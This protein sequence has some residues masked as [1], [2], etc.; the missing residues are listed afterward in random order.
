MRPIV[1]SLV[2]WTLLSTLASGQQQDTTMIP[3]ELALALIDVGFSPGG[4]PA[5]SVGHV[6][7]DFPTE[8]LPK[9]V[10]VLGTLSRTT[11]R[12]TPISVTVVAVGPDSVSSASTSLQSAL[13]RAGWKTPPMPDSRGGFVSLG[14]SGVWGSA[15]CRDSTTLW[16]NVEPRD[17]AG[18]LYHFMVTPSAQ[19]S[20][21]CNP[22]N[23]RHAEAFQR[24][25]TF[26]FPTLRPPAG[27][28]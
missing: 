21:V 1:S 28:A 13:A 5:I 20:S 15:L 17:R 24:T 12:D 3:R 7:K 14:P 19:R 26:T 4:T 18:S 23:F 27:V 11:K 8:L 9:N 6:P 10:K 25:E 22:E 2:L 16:V